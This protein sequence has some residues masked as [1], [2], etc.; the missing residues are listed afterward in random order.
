MC[1]NKKKLIIFDLDGVILDSKKNMSL[2]WNTVKKKYKLNISFSRY[3]KYVGLPFY[4][5]LQNLNISKK[6]YYKI[7][8][9]YTKF[10]AYHFKKEIKLFPKIN[11]ILTILKKNYKIALFTSKSDLTTK[12]VLK[13][14]NIKFDYLITGN[15]VKKGKPNPEGVNKILK[16]LNTNKKNAFYVGDTKFDLIAAKKAKVKYI[17]ALWGFDKTIKTMSLK[18][19]LDL[20]NF[21]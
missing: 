14:I 21:F 4:T 3:Q 8:N 17:H 5:I 2:S 7:K 15:H 20:I 6:N 18:R 10:S 9:D 19:P 1:L 12:L 13:N 16:K 11:Y